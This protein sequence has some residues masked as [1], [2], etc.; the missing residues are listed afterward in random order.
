MSSIVQVPHNDLFLQHDDTT[1]QYKDDVLLVQQYCTS[2]FTWHL[3]C[4]RSCS[5]KVIYVWHQVEPLWH[6]DIMTL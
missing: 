5:K 4:H 6:Y 1:K 3:L 2:K